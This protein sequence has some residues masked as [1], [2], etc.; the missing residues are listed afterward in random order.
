MGDLSD[1]F[2][3]KEFFST[4]VYQK[5]LAGNRTPAHYIDARLVGILQDIRNYFN[6]AVKI[7]SGFR[8][9]AENFT[10]GS[11][12]EWSLHCFGRAADIVVAGVPSSEVQ[13]FLKTRYSGIG[14]GM[15][16]TFTHLDTRNTKQN[17]MWD[18][19]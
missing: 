6:K 17:I 15:S 9:M 19:A 18:Y 14:I 4:D 8:T 16:D 13:M 11:K 1:N 12:T 10:A 7:N 2:D 5:L 3:S